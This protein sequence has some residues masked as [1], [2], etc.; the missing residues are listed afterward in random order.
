[1]LFIAFFGLSVFPQIDP[2]TQKLSF[3]DAT[4]DYWFRWANWDGG[5]FRGIV[6]HGY[7]PEQTV[8]FPLYP[9]LMKV[10]T[11][12]G[13]GANWS[14]LLISHVSAVV[15]LFFLF[16]LT[17]LDFPE[18]VAKRAVFALLIFPTSFYLGAVYSESLFLAVTVAS[19]YFLRTGRV[20]LGSI[21][22]GA[23][24]ATRLVG[25]AT[26][27]S[28]LVEHPRKTL[29]ILLALIPFA[30]YLLYQEALFQ[31][32]FGFLTNESG[33]N[34]HFT[35]PWEPVLSAGSYLYSAG[36]FQIGNAARVLVELAFF[37]GGL[38]G[39]WFSWHKL[40]P[41]YTIFLGLSLILPAFSGTLI[42]IPRYMLTIFPIFI[43]LG[44]IKNEL[45]QKIGV[46]FSLLLLSAYAILFILGYWVT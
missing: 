28:L 31:N 37:L 44:L 3:A 39:L 25:I 41:S 2:Y 40:R 30:L 11:F 23:A 6:E 22:A 9:L 1:M 13:L 17:A 8:F 14:G 46:I 5:H 18:K 27:V 19:F 38:A 42:A 4:T 24:I 45:L 34:R 12:I 32:P 33:W 26:W 21:F 43:L 20:K 15:A 36:I 35:L 16:K 29:I 7:L 10:L